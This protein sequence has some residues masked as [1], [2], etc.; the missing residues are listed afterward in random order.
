MLLS[1]IV[2]VLILM[3]GFPGSEIDR[4]H[5]LDSRREGCAFEMIV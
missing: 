3:K 2:L 1:L 4:T 5:R